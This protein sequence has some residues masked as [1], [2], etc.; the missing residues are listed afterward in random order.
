MGRARIDLRK[1][2]PNPSMRTQKNVY[3]TP[4]QIEL[5]KSVDI[6]FVGFVHSCNS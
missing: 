1:S 5:F 4:A 3:F 6:E 2:T